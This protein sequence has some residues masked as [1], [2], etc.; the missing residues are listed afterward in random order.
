MTMIIRRTVFALGAGLALGIAAYAQAAS[1]G[2]EIG[3]PAPA[4]TAVDSKGK[5]VRLTDLRGKTVVLEWTNHD[6]PYVRKHY[7]SS[8]MQRIQAEAAKDGVVW[9][10]VISSSPGTQG[11]VSAA[12]ADALTAKRNA[13]PAHVL[14]DEKGSIGLKYGAR[15]TPHMFVINAEGMLVYMGGIDNKPT[16]NIADIGTATNYVGQALAAVKNGEA[17]PTPVSRPYGC[18]IKYQGA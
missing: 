6:C 1:S 4:F 9:L 15:V 8:N 2:P 12:E 14:L 10:S 13:T 16:S 18:S 11:H 17:V 5:E 3:K 7:N